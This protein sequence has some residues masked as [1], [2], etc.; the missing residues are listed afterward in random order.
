MSTRQRSKRP[1]AKLRGPGDRAADAARSPGCGMS[2]TP[3]RASGGAAPARASATSAPTASPSAT[4]RRSP[5][6]RVARHSAGLDRRL[7]LPLAQRAHPGHRPRRARPQAVPLP[8]EL[9]GGAGRDQVR[10]DAGLQRGAARRSGTGSSSDLGRAG[11]AA[12][13]G[14]R[15]R[16]AAAG[17]HLHPRRQRRVRPDQPLVRPDHAAGRARRR[18]AARPCASSSG[19]RAARP[20]AS[21]SATGGSPG[22]CD[23]ARSFPARDLFQYVDEDGAQQT[24]GSGDV[25]DYLREITGEDFTAKDFRT[26]AGTILARRGA[27]ASSAPSTRSAKPSRPSCK[28]IDQVAEQLNNTRAV[29]RKYYVHPMVFEEYLAGNM[30]NG[31]G[32]SPGKAKASPGPGLNAEERAV[33]RLLQKETRGNATTY[34]CNRRRRLA[35]LHR[36][37]HHRFPHPCFLHRRP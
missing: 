5:R 34:C 17:V 1:A 8:S 19:A 29:C 3:C 23:D 2:A 15:H 32:K 25:N 21:S 4:R 13:E 16:G 24:I 26:W 18:S 27:A 36:P 35:R 30:R 14:A 37:R 9:A 31:N 6:I 7:D 10:P 12:G 28:A 20:T 22:S 33:V 11:P